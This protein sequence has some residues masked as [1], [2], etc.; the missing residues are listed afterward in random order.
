MRKNI[1]RTEQEFFHDHVAFLQRKFK[2][3][4]NLPQQKRTL[5][6]FLCKVCIF[7]QVSN[8]CVPEIMC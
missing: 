6:G 8:T 5:P 7:A 3:P 4:R 2:T 1:Y